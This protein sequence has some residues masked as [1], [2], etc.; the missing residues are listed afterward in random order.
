[1]DKPIVLAVDDTPENLDVV[2]G[3]LTPEY[4]VRAAI[5]GKMAIKIAE[6]Q[7]VDIILL[8]IMMPEMDGYEVCERLKSNPATKDI[9]I[10]FLTAKDQTEDEAKGF[11]LGAADYILKPVSPPIL[12]ARVLT[13]VTLKRNMDE[14]QGAYAVIEQQ[15]DRMQS[16]LNVGRKIQLDM[17]PSDF[18][19]F[20]D[21]DDVDIYA[22]LRPAREIGGDLYD[23]F[24]RSPDEICICVGDVSGK[25]VPAALF[26]AVTKT[27]LKSKAMDDPSPA[28][29]ITRVNDE[30]SKDN[31]NFMF[32]TIF[33]GILNLSK[34]ELIYT[35]AGHNPSF[36]CRDNDLVRLD[37]LHGPVVGAMEGF[38]YSEDTVPLHNADIVVAYTDGITEAINDAEELFDEYRLRECIVQTYDTL[39][40][41]VNATVAAVD[42]YAGENEQFDDI[43]MLA[44]IYHGDDESSSHNQLTLTIRNDLTEIPRV[45]EQFGIFA[46]DFNLPDAFVNA[47]NLVFDELLANTISYGYQDD[48]EHLIEILLDYS[49]DR[50][51]L[52]LGDDGSPFNPLSLATPDTTSP[53]D[54]R[55]IGGL[56]VHLVR[57]LMDS[58]EYQR[59]QNK[60]V[61]TL[62]KKV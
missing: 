61:L 42:D 51:V 46:N 56:G 10:I 5:N 19:A 60:N 55:Q 14:L 50:M 28:S 39:E 47:I 45:I 11:A 62:V 52:T 18:P 13:H 57:R 58:V 1:M 17:V 8:D 38:A 54:Q 24:A 15:K 12:E 37:N 48:E 23:F 53:L 7:P 30:I 59:Q 31:P 2:K 41:L 33:F 27:L 40:N 49:S 44:A 22:M 16:E 21:R 9:P 36:I 32:V 26:M 29:I 25:G 3:I 20:P 35:N 4:T 6:S 43:T 34:G